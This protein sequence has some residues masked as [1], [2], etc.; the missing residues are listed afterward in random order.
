M[1]NRD[2][3]EVLRLEGSFCRLFEDDEGMTEGKKAQRDVDL[4]INK[5]LEAGGQQILI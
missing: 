4:M 2:E 1:L 3:L 5:E